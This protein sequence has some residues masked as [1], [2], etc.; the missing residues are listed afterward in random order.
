[1]KIGSNYLGNGQCEF[2]VWAPFR[3]SVA[4]HIVSPQDQVIPLQKDEWGYWQETV[5]ADP[6]TLYVY[7]LDGSLERPDPASHYQPEGVHGSSQVVD[8]HFDWTDN[9]WQ[10]IP[11]KDLIIYELHVG[12]FTP[13]GTF[14]SIIPRLSYLQD[15]GITAIEIMP[16][17]QFPGSRNWGYDG[18]Y[19]YGVQESYGGPAGLKKLVD[20]CHQAGI[21]VILDVVYNHLGPEGNYLWAY[22]PYFTDQYRTPWGNAVNFDGAYSNQV[23]NFFIQNALYWLDKYH[24]DALRVDAIHAIYDMSAQPFLQELGD[25]VANFNRTTPVQRYVIAESDLNDVRV[26][27]PREDGGFGHDAQWCDDFHH[28]LHTLLTG[29]L[30]G[31]YE[32]F[33]KIEQLAVALREGYIYS[34]Q[35]SSF[36]KRNHGNSAADRPAEQFV[37]CIQNHDQIGNRLIGDRLSTLVDFQGLKVAAATV[38]LSPYVPMLFM[39]EEYGEE[40]PFQYFVSH[41]DPDLIEGVRTGRAEEFKAFGWDNAPD[42]QGTKVFEQSKLQWEK[43]EQDNYAVLRRWYKRLIQLRKETPA[44]A[45][46]DRQNLNVSSLSS[47]KVIVIHRTA[48]DSQAIGLINFAHDAVTVSPQIPPGNFSKVIDSAD[49]EWM[50][51]GSQLSQQLQAGQSLTLAPLSFALYAQ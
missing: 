8:H 48:G 33:G 22:G 44:L 25:A 43:I 12:T 30:S 4:V 5:K 46:L 7:Q 41:S 42:P 36:R 11:L 2:R 45:K 27:K 32:D 40:A 39:G 28:I 18:V 47:E 38:L 1:M 49:K 26:I 50:G 51:E 6:G 37:V 15:L 3:D 14:E 17:A 31:Y 9:S 13:E 35:Y 21:A 19:V 34:G 16:V 29:E 10:G 24:I 23:R 20:A